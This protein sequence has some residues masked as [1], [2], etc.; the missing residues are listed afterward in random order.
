[1]NRFSYLTE[2]WDNPFAG[3]LPYCS[4]AIIN[5]RLC[6]LD[7]R[8]R[9]VKKYIIVFY[10]LYTFLECTFLLAALPVTSQVPIKRLLC[11][12]TAK[13]VLFLSVVRVQVS[14]LQ[15]KTSGNAQDRSLCHNYMLQHTNKSS[16]RLTA[17]TILSF[18]AISVSKEVWNCGHSSCI[19]SAS[20]ESSHHS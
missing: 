14:S 12:G 13:A 10:M 1:M 17:S 20:K 15:H 11:L 6:Q 4:C 2:L 8:L 18:R 9:I 16:D 5:K 7:C 19:L 3:H